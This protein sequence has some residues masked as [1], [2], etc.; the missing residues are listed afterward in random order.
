MPSKSAQM[1]VVVLIFCLIVR[2]YQ[3]LPCDDDASC[4]QRDFS[5]KFR[6]TDLQGVYDPKILELADLQGAYI[7]QLG[8]HIPPEG[9]IAAIF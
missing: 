5:L 1:I 6:H 8:A 9:C 4:H 2:C 7:S 3:C